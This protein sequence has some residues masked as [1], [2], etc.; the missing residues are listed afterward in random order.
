MYNLE[1]S[2]DYSEGEDYSNFQLAKIFIQPPVNANNENSNT[3][4]GD[5]NQPTGDASILLDNQLLRSAVLQINTL[6]GPV[7][8]EDKEELSNKNKKHRQ[9][10][11]KSYQE[12]NRPITIL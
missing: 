7:I 1:V 12:K 8:K 5:V 3:D 6:S 2:T 9:L 10:S 11:A 4:S